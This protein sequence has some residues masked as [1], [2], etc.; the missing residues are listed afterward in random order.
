MRGE[1]GYGCI[2]ILS[3]SRVRMWR[4]E[5]CECGDV[6]TEAEETHGILERL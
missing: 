5:G 4:G 6:D 1:E 2:G 3:R